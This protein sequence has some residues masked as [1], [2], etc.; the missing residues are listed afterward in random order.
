LTSV[1]TKGKHRLS[2]KRRRAAPTYDNLRRARAIGDGT[3]F[4]P[5]LLGPRI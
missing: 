2:R 4:D 5:A 1:D 3:L